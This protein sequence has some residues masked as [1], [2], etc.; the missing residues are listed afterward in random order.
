MYPPT[1]RYSHDKVLIVLRNGSAIQV[2]TGSTN[3]SLTWLYVNANHI[4]VFEDANVASHY[5]EV[6]EKSWQVWALPDVGDPNA[7]A[8]GRQASEP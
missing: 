2:L 8:R 5:D 4:L 7:R 6:F 1:I 3:F